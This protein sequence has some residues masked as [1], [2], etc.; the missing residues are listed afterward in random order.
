[1]FATGEEIECPMIVYQIL[2]MKARVRMGDLPCVNGHSI[3]HAPE[4]YLTRSGDEPPRDDD[5]RAKT[6]LLFV[7]RG[8]EG[9]GEERHVLEAR[10]IPDG[11][12]VGDGPCR[13]LRMA[14]A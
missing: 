1:M 3:S 13:E 6:E 7:R 12:L 5:G 8:G 11:E 9:G 4:H 10:R 2:D 14:S